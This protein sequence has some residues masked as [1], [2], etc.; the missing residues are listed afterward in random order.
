[1][2]EHIDIFYGTLDITE[3]VTSAL[4]RPLFTRFSLW[5]QL[6]INLP[7]ETK[8]TVVYYINKDYIH[9]YFT[10]LN[11]VMSPVTKFDRKQSLITKL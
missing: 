11:G 5:P 1:M 2:S 9:T 10:G 8:T 7:L 4:E 6:I 3:K